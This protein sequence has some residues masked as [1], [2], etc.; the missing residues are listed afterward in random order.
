MWGV[1]GNLGKINR[2]VHFNRVEDTI[3]W[4]WNG[5]KVIQIRKYKT[6]GL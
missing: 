2:K 5:W 3:K 6:Q 4:I 1:A